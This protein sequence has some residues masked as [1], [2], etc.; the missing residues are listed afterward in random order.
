MSSNLVVILRKIYQAMSILL[1]FPDIIT[2]FVAVVEISV[3][4]FY[5]MKIRPL[6]CVCVC[7]GNILKPYEV[8]FISLIIHPIFYRGAS[9]CI[10]FPLIG[11]CWLLNLIMQN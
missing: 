10:K 4:L 5:K 11:K 7:K 3:S 8:H 1:S 9:S 2:D 6:F